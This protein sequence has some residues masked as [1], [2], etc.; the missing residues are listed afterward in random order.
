MNTTA[1]PMHQPVPPVQ[2]DALTSYRLEMIEKTLASMSDSVKQLVS[3][4][5]K[6]IETRQAIERAFDELKDHDKR[7][8]DVEQEMPT[9]KLTR[10]WIIGG[11]MGV[12]GIMGIQLFKLMFAS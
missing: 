5:Q 3:L 2:H 4:E 6:H 9:M 7:I 10:G 12:F 8:R 11:V 1:S